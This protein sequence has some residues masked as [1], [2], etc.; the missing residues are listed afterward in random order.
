MFRQSRRPAAGE[1]VGSS[2]NLFEV[3]CFKCG[4]KGHYQIECENEPLCFVSKEEGHT[5]IQCPSRLSKPDL[6]KYGYGVND[7]GFY[8]LEGGAD[9]EDQLPPNA[10]VVVVTE[11]ETTEESIRSDLSDMWE[12]KWDWKVTVVRR[13]CFFVIH[14]SKAALRM[15]KKSGTVTLPISGHKAVVGE[16]FSEPYAVSWLEECWVLITGIANRLCQIPLI[17]EII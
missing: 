4:R 5:S 13:N 15:A 17:K 9:E 6:V 11:G 2:Q 12:S 3:M 7:R 8:L 1:R 14:P 10:A 16:P